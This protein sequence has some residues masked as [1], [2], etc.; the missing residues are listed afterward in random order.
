VRVLWLSN[1]VL[2][3]SDTGS[4]G[5]WLDAMA[6]GL[7]AS[8]QVTHGNISMGNVRELTSHDFPPLRQWLVPSASLRSDGL[9]SRKVVEIVLSTI[10]DFAPDIIHIWGVEAWWGLL[11][12]RGRLKQPVLLEMQGLKGAVSRVFNGGLTFQE[13]ESC[14]GPKEL[15]LRR[16]IEGDR[17]KFAAW[18]PF[19]KE[20]MA[21][22]HHVAT[23]TPWVEAWVRAANPGCITYRTELMLRRPFYDATPWI[24]STSSPVLFCSA[25]Y[26]APYKGVH[27]VIR[28]TALL[29][30]RFPNIQL[31]IAGPYQRRGLRQDGYVRWLNK[32]CEESGVAD[33]I[34]WLGRLSAAQIVA[35]SLN[36]SVFVM[37][38]HIEN[39]C[40]SMQEALYLG[41][42]TVSAYTGG[43]PS[44]AR[45]EEA[46]LYYA[47]GD[48]VM[49][50]N[51]VERLLTD[52]HLAV[53]LSRNARAVAVE[54]NMPE[55][56]IAKQLKIYRKIIE[57]HSDA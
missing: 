17:R 19:E 22:C 12:A 28:A 52:R 26:A 31:R 39:C 16:S 15:I 29:S 40:T 11:N 7:A 30:S 18:A 6:Q 37:P 2:S 4:T 14:R 54:R 25:A 9:P 5:T 24:Q 55:A 34:E 41:V 13:Q 33:R 57:S 46:A 42:P 21:G 45:E 35:E 38:S 47:P 1:S 23:Q 32:F 49:C 44:L 36:C 51:Q 53:H 20:I 10:N 48:E 50:A 3:G 27:D 43:V 56:I 8:G